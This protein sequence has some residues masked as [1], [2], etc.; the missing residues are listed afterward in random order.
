MGCAPRQAGIGRSDELHV[1]LHVLK[2]A[3]MLAAYW[4][5]HYPRFSPLLNCSCRSNG[6][7]AVNDGERR[8]VSLDVAGG[9]SHEILHLERIANVQDVDRAGDLHWFDIDTNRIV[10]LRGEVKQRLSDLS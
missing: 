3:R 6:H 9:F 8:L 10:M 1:L 4:A 5:V 7:R 2:H